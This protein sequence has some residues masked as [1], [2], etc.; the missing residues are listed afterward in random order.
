M[1]SWIINNLWIKIISLLLA[2]I[3]WIYVNGELD[4]EKRIAR[5]FYKSSLVRPV[6]EDIPPQQIRKKS[7]NRGYI[8]EK[9]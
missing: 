6:K 5:K 3:T 7:M 8:M 2:I 9:K 4:K 1:K